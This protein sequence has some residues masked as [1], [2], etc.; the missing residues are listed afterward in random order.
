MPTFGDIARWDPAA[1]EIAVTRWGAVR[2][3]LTTAHD[4]LTAARPDPEA[5]QGVA[6]DQARTVH[7]QLGAWLADTI[8]AATASRTTLA[9]AT[10]ALTDLYSDL[11]RALAYANANG[12]EV[13]DN[14]PSPTPSRPRK[15]PGCGPGRSTCGTAPPPMPSSSPPC[16]LSPPVASPS[17][18]RCSPRPRTY[19]NLC[20]PHPPAPT[21]SS[22]A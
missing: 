20:S 17:T 4:T 8:A 6:A 21:C 15:Q 18:P 19:P 5:W 2:K 22:T 12:F 13:A 7:D 16:K 3:E 9:A 14:G 11:R 1:L 10:D